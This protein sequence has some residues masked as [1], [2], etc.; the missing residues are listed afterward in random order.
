[1]HPAGRSTGGISL[2]VRT[3]WLQQLHPHEC[4]F[5]E[6]CPG[7]VIHFSI[8]GPHPLHLLVVHLVRDHCHSWRQLAEL[9]FEAC[10]HIVQPLLVVGDM[11]VVYAEHDVIDECGSPRHTPYTAD[12]ICWQRQCAPWCLLTALWTHRHT[13]T[14]TLRSLDR[15]YCNADLQTLTN[16]RPVTTIHGFASFA[17]GGSDHWP[18]RLTWLANCARPSKHGLPRYIDA[19]PDAPALRWIRDDCKAARAE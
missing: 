6:V 5:V 12:G 14:R 11:N 17:P 9:T 1:M 10:S 13:A 8:H 19:M 4:S 15:V 2:Y 16:L 7:R 18:V 3:S